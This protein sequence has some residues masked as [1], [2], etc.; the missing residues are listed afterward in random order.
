MTDPIQKD[1]AKAKET[2]K[3]DMAVLGTDIAKVAAFWSDYRL[4]LICAACLF[5]GG[6][7]GY[8]IHS[9]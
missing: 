1:F 3:A 2:L 8:K 4:Y 6:I 9:L 5:V 7:I